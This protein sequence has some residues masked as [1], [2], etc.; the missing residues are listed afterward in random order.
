MHGLCLFMLHGDWLYRARNFLSFKETREK[1]SGSFEKRTSGQIRRLKRKHLG[2]EYINVA[3]HL[4]VSLRSS[5]SRIFRPRCVWL[6]VQYMLYYTLARAHILDYWVSPLDL[7]Q[8][9]LKSQLTTRWNKKTLPT[10]R[11]FLTYFLQDL[12]TCTLL[13]GCHSLL[14]QKQESC[15]LTRLTIS[16][17][18]NQFYRYA[19]AL[20]KTCNSVW[21]ALF[22][23]WLIWVF[24]FRDSKSRQF[25]VIT[26]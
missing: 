3:L 17:S 16:K 10:T 24:N 15:L 19:I 21:V 14:F 8:V 18:V 22:E 12:V 25:S 6:M 26:S 20:F 7:I 9:Y 2:Y 1:V 13:L 23:I 11:S 5:A 4:A